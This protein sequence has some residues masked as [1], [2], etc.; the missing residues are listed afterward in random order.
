VKLA[1]YHIEEYS[2]VIGI[3]PVVAYLY[4]HIT[5][6]NKEVGLKVHIEK[7][8]SMLLSHHQNSGQNQDTQ[9][10]N[11]MFKHVPQFKYFGTSVASQNL[12]LEEFKRTLN[13]GNACYHSVQ[14]LLSS[15]LLSKNIKVKIYKTIILPVVLYGCETL[16]LTLKE[17]HRLWVL[18][19]RLHRTIFGPKRDRVMGAR[20]E[21][22]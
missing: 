13:S 8:K 14:N 16:S 22:T 12:I 6:A 11:R 18:E 4:M 20:E 17:E 10:A 15:C 2:V 9:I 3:R 1:Q 7:T 5:D 21:T 19:N